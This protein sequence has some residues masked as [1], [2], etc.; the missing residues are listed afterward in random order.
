MAVE[1][2]LVLSQFL[3][4]VVDIPRFQQEIDASP[5][6]TTARDLGRGCTLIGDVL[7]VWFKAELSELEDGAL[8]ALAAAHTGEPL[9]PTPKVVPVEFKTVPDVHL[10]G[11]AEPD[12]KPVMVNSPATEGTFTWL[13]SCSDDLNATPPASGRG[14]GDKAVLV[15]D[16]P[17]TKEAV[18]QFIEP[19]E[20]HDGHV[21]WRGAWDFEDSW[22]ISIRMPATVP[23]ENVGGTGNCDLRMTPYGFNVIIPAAGDGTHD[24]DLATAVPIPDG[25]TAKTDSGQG[26]WDVEQYWSEEVSAVPDGKGVFNF[27]DIPLEMYFCRNMDCGNPLGVWDLDAYK[28]EWVSSRWKIVFTAT[29]V[30]PGAGKIGGY[31]MTFR[32]GAI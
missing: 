4:V 5:D 14:T 10:D 15:F 23:V 21:S 24:I 9:P 20:L 32:P 28:A 27:Y 19:V 1:L 30:T 22:S 8:L 18:I 29:K 25:Y 31:L 3:N 26:F 11:P 17:D 12:K 2:Q 16:A 13:S 6:I 7:S